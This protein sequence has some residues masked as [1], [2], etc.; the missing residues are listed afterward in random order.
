MNLKKLLTLSAAA[1]MVSTTAV[2]CGGKDKETLTTAAEY[3]WQMYRNTDNTTVTGSFDVVNK[4]LVGD[5]E[6]AVSWALEA[7]G[8]TAAFAIETKNENFS[9]V[10]VGYYDGLVTEESTVKLVPTFTVGKKS[11]TLAEVYADDEAR[12]AIDF[13]TPVLTLHTHADWDKNDGATLNIRGVVVDIIATGSSAN[14]IYMVDAEGNGYYVYNPSS[15]GAK[16]GDEIVVTGK[17]SDYSGQEEFGKGATFGIVTKGKQDTIT[18]ADGSAD[19]AAATSNK[20]SGSLGAKYQN[21]PVKLTKCTPTRI[22]GSYYYFKVGNGTTEFNLYKNTY[23]LSDDEI[24]AWTKTF[25]DALK[26]GYTLTIEGISTVYSS[27][28]QVYP[29][30]LKSHVLTK[31]AELTVDEKHAVVADTLKGAIAAEYDSDAEISFEIP[32][33]AEVTLAVTSPAENATV[34]VKDG[35]IVVSPSPVA[36]ENK[37]TATV[38]IGESTKTVELTVKT[39]VLKYDG[40]KVKV[41]TADLVTGNEPQTKVVTKEAKTY[42]GAKKVEVTYSVNNLYADYGAVYFHKT[43]TN[44]TLTISVPNGYVIS[45]LV[46]NQYGKYGNW[47]FHKGADLTGEEIASTKVDH[48][49]E[50]SAIRTALPNCQTVTIEN[51]STEYNNSFYDITLTIVEKGAC[52][53]SANLLGY[54]GSN[55]AYG[56]G[57]ATV[58]GVGLKYTQVAC[59]KNDD[60]ATKNNGIQMRNKVKDGGVASSIETTTAIE[61]GI[62][63]VNLTFAATKSAYDT[64]DMMKFEFSN[65]A[66][67][68][69]AEV[70]IMDTV[71]NQAEYTVTPSVATY[72]YVRIT[73]N[74]GYT[75][76]WDSIV[77]DY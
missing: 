54:A 32:S 8:S 59:F 38:K 70:I 50:N 41:S 10:K 42:D 34:A 27:A 11:I 14:S 37:V 60:D 44:D 17:R 62:K 77:I 26:N 67:F 36:T 18:F 72:K 13:S 31:E 75:T 12:H 25:E 7:T 1:L 9:T 4:V 63:A 51:P 68:A 43:A 76:Y 45:E 64:K 6:V 40:Y 21:V 16:I 69:N 30:K 56:D 35:K 52:L 61:T 3:L 28:Y 22:D 58:N 19:W 20:T 39:A 73:N 74:V 57:T 5:V 15:K 71:K 23:F 2:S 33:Y 47:V 29:C 55:V 53:T 48:A 46:M 24:T 49:T 66:D 65:T